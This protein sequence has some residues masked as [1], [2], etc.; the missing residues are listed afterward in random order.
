MINFEIINL[1]TTASTNAYVK[2]LLFTSDL[3]EGAVVVTHEQSAGK[4][5]GTNTW[6]SEPG[7]N[8]TFSLLLK[9]TFLAADKMFLV[10]KAVSLGMVEFLNSF[11][12][13]FTIKWPN[14]IYFNDKKIAGILIENQLLGNYFGYSIIGIG[15]NVNQQ[16]FLSDAPNPMSMQQIF[17]VEFDL[18]KTLHQLLE[19]IDVWF[20]RLKT[21]NFKLINDTYHSMLYRNSGFHKFKTSQTVFEARIKNVKDDGQM[22]LQK[23]SGKTLAFYFK[24]VEFLLT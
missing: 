12:K 8:L 4:G 21:G 18:D 5:Q 17:K 20:Q 1:K 23:T 10:S 2:R 14:D 3:P 13:K 11:G 19:N 24:E 9:P 16:K 6:E 22:M 15:L 7:K